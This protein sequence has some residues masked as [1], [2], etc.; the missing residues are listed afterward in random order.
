[1]FLS[2][3]HPTPPLFPCDERAL[4]SISLFTK[5]ADDSNFATSR[6]ARFL[7]FIWSMMSSWVNII[8]QSIRPIEWCTIGLIFFLNF[9]VTIV[10]SS[11]CNKLDACLCVRVS[12]T[13]S[14]FFKPFFFLSY[15]FVAWHAAR[16]CF[17]GCSSF[18]FARTVHFYQHL[19]GQLNAKSIRYVSWAHTTV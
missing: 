8:D 16:S 6:F 15:R 13:C 7:R 2:H 19:T 1:M 4:F 5:P 14:S 17:F 10:V 11:D 3:S 9:K 12:S 18:P